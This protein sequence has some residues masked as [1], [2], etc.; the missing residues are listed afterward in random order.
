MF[1]YVQ[2]YKGKM[3]NFLLVMIYI[4]EKVCSYL[5]VKVCLYI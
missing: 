3:S 5:C 1:K 2:I 4:Y